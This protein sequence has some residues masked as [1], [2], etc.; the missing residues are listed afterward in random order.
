MLDVPVEEL[1]EQA[2]THGLPLLRIW[3]AQL[4]HFNR[5]RAAREPT[6]RSVVARRR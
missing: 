3:A 2:H 6:V 5:S 4:P 1:A